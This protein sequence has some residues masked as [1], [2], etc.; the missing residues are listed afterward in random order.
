M[1]SFLSPLLRNPTQDFRLQNARTGTVVADRLLQ[2]FDSVSRRTGLLKHVSLP[3]G[4]AMIIAPGS[5]I[6]T[7]F[8]KFPIDVV[9]VAKD[10]RIVKT[11]ST[12]D[13]WRLAAAWQ[14]YAVIELPAGTLE[15]SATAR[16]DHLLVVPR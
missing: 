10:G 16:G 5:A 6:H 2:A 11:R 14:A 3:E 12:L 1:P 7:W 13:P 8:M 9:F 4:C 15:R